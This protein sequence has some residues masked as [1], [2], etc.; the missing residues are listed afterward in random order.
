MWGH[1][2]GGWGGAS[3]VRRMYNPSLDRWGVR[4]DGKRNA[5]DAVEDDTLGR[6]YSIILL[7]VL[8]YSSTTQFAH[9]LE[10]NTLLYRGS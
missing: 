9:F 7:N 3:Q 6:L 8:P 10:G 4:D 5:N 1:G 2:G